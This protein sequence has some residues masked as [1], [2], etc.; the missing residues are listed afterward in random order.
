MMDIADTCERRRFLIRRWS[1]LLFTLAMVALQAGSPA[2][3][4]MLGLPLV[5]AGLAV[6]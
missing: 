6:Q 3:A 5:T 4:A 2:R 1:L